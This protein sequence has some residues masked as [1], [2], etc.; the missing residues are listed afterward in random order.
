MEGA[1]LLGGATKLRGIAPKFGD[2]RWWQ[3][4]GLGFLA[5]SAIALRMNLGMVVTKYD[6]ETGMAAKD[7]NMKIPLFLATTFFIAKVMVLP[8]VNWKPE[9]IPARIYT[10]ILLMTVLG[11]IGGILEYSS[12]QFCPISVVVMLRVGGLVS[13]TALESAFI[14]R[15]SL[16]S[17]RSAGGLAL[18]ILGTAFAAWQ[19]SEKEKWSAFAMLGISLALLS[20]LSDATEQVVMEDI[21]QDEEFDLDVWTFTGVA[22]LMGLSFMLVLLGTAQFIPGD[23]H[24]GVQ[25]NTVH[26]LQVLGVVMVDMVSASQIAKSFGA[27]TKEAVLSFRIIAAWIFGS[28]VFMALPGSGFGEEWFWTDLVMKSIGGVSIIAGVSLYLHFRREGE[29]DAGKVSATD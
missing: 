28:I 11:A 1:S 13:M 16:L 5:V 29:E 23:G 19:H 26:T 14:T 21:L 12:Y 3:L 25:E 10:K 6:P 24:G 27:T 18:V 15:R 2:T 8:F 17:W 9:S 4:V 20:S 7:S 22:G